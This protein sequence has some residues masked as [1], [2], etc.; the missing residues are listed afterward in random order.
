MNIQQWE[1][2]VGREI[3]ES[4]RTQTVLASSVSIIGH[5]EAR[6]IPAIA[7]FDA[8]RM[9]ACMHVEMGKDFVLAF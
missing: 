8:K 4:G 1:A 9:R 2:N 3:H 7:L 5:F 6:R